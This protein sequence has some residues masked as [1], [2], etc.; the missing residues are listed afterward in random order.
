MFAKLLLAIGHLFLVLQPEI[1]LSSLTE[2][3]LLYLLL[4][5]AETRHTVLR[6]CG[7]RGSYSP[8]LDLLHK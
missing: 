3:A 2:C 4:Q 8:V 6:S 1:Q 5:I 7:Q